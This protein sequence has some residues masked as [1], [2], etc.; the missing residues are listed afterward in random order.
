MI[1]YYN[2]ITRVIS[3][4]HN[5]CALFVVVAW[6]IISSFIVFGMTQPIVRN[7]LKYLRKSICFS[8]ISVFLIPLALMVISFSTPSTKIIT[9]TNIAISLQ[10]VLVFPLISSLIIAK[11]D[12][13]SF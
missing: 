8:Y 9:I 10:F 11:I 7:Q 6:P 5:T 1:E 3:E 12:R 2:N 13:W 4:D